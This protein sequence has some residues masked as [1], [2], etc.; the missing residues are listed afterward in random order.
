[1]II[2]HGNRAGNRAAAPIGEQTAGGD[3][4]WYAAYSLHSAGILRSI[5]ISP[6]RDGR[7]VTLYR[8]INCDG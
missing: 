5:K 2:Y 1:M 7:D 8:G 3:A 6:C 4:E